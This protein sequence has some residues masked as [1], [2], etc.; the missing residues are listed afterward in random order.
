MR[1]E[2]RRIGPA[3]KIMRG[4]SVLQEYTLAEALADDKLKTAIVRNKWEPIVQIGEVV[5]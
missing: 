2:G 1:I 5:P 3:Y 4:D